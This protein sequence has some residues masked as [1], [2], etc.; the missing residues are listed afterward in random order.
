MKN[1]TTEQITYFA[2]VL[3]KLLDGQSVDNHSDE[4]PDYWHDISQ[5]IIACPTNDPQQR[6]KAFDTEITKYPEEQEIRKVVF[7][8][9]LKA[10]L[11]SLKKNIKEIQGVLNADEILNTIWKPPIW[12]IPDILPVGLTILA[13]PPKVGKSWL[14]LQI[15]QAVAAGGHVLGESVEKGPIFY[16]ALEDPP[17]RLK[18]RMLIQKW[19]LGLD[20]EFL[21]VGIF[22]KSIG[23][24][25]KGGAEKLA[26]YIEK[27]GFRLVVIDTLSRSI[28]GDQNDSREMTKWLSPLQGIAQNNNCA[29]VLVD[30]HRKNGGA[31]NDVVSDILGSTAKGAMADTICGLYKESGKNGA[32][33]AIVGREVEKQ[34][35]ELTFDSQVCYW[36]NNGAANKFNMTQRR[37]E[38]IDALKKLGRS[39]LGAIAKKIKQHESNTHNRLQDLGNAGLV[40][41]EEV[42]TNVFYKLP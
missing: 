25:R 17:R 38:I 26:K 39:Q 1:Y 31:N 2:T 19:P 3:R 5:A 22:D 8:A 18:E 21:P 34:T 15:S 20:A 16:L 27:M 36:Q 9:D 40:I 10:D 13:G 24:L 42:G 6:E 33:L 7:D 29:L 14:A 32:K 12:A 4:L 37:Q 41:R 23:D 28:H 11:E 30:H 35:L